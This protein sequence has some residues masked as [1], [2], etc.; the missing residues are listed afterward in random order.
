MKLRLLTLTAACTAALATTSIASPQDPAA[1]DC[2]GN[3]PRHHQWGD[4]LEH[5]TKAFDLTADQQAK[6]SP[7]LE[8]AKPQI[9]AARQEARQEMKAIHDNTRSQIR[10]LLTTAQQTKLDAMQKA[11][12]PAANDSRGNWPRHRHWGNGLAHMTKTLDLTAEQQAKIAPILEQAKPQIMA[13]RQESGQKIKTIRDSI[14]SQLRPLLTAP[15][16]AKLDAIQKARE[17]MRK[18]RQEMREVAKQ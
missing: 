11:H 17:D 2:S 9:A 1:K 13:I 5:M 7:I 16:Q 3:S 12:D 8:Q 18:A 6:I 10:P 4:G 14:T 15:Q